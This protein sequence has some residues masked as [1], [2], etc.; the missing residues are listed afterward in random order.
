MPFD[1]NYQI[2]DK[3]KPVG[4]K[5]SIKDLALIRQ[6]YNIGAFRWALEKVTGITSVRFDGNAGIEN[7]EINGAKINIDFET[8]AER[9]SLANGSTY[10]RNNPQNVED[11]DAS[12]NARKIIKDAEKCVLYAYDDKGETMTD[13]KT[14]EKVPKP[15][16][17]GMKLKGTLTI[18]YGHTGRDVKPGMTITKQKADELLKKDMGTAT[19][20][21]KKHVKV[22]LTQNEF[23]ALTSFTYNIGEGQFK[24]STMLTL[25][26]EEKYSEASN[27]FRRWT[28]SK[29]EV[30][31]GLKIRRSKE[32]ELFRKV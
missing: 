19:R 23:D 3:Y 17:K 32:R 25:L 29:G 26:N 15:F 12:N 30:M 28:K 31:E 27:E 1:K 20:A 13:P 8:E 22:P 11:L 21:I 18:G 10:I 24:K 4:E 6:F 2:I 5:F 16:K 9:K 14:K 7:I